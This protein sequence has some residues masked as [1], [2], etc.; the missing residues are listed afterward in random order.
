MTNAT[1]EPAVT[2]LYAR[3]VVFDGARA[4]DFYRDAL[5]AEET[6]RYTGPDGKIVHA[7]LRLG[8]AAIAVKDADDG[9]PAPTSLGGSPVIMALDVSDADA[10]AEAMLRGGATVIHPVAD[11]HYGQ[12][13]GRLADPFGHLWMISQ[14][15]EDLTPEEIQRRTDELFT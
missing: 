7:M 12:R 15:I 3:L 5:G 14:T 8:D 11:Q 6:E 2:R 13:G 9:D 10:V 4:I 1:G